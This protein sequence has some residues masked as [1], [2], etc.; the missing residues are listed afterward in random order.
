VKTS[1]VSLRARR[2][3]LGAA[4]IFCVLFLGSCRAIL[5]TDDYE[6]SIDVFCGM[7][8]RCF[9]EDA[10]TCRTTVF[11]ELTDAFPETRKLWLTTFSD[12]ACF[13]RCVSTRRCMNTPPVCSFDVCEKREDCCFFVQGQK[14]CNLGTN[15]CCIRKGSRC[16]TDEDCCPGAGLCTTD[17]LPG[18]QPVCGG[19]ACGIPG[20]PCSIGAQCCTEV[21]R[22][23]VCAEDICSPD[24]L[25]CGSDD[26]CCEHFCNE[27]TG[28]CGKEVCGVETEDCGDGIPCCGEL[29]CYNGKCTSPG[30]QPDGIE[31]SQHD[32]CCGKRCDADLTACRACTDAGASCGVNGECCSG[33]CKDGFCAD[34]L[35]E[36]EKCVLGGATDCCLGSC[37][38]VDPSAAKVDMRCAPICGPLTCGHDECVAG[39]PLKADCS[40]CTQAVCAVDSYCCC[41]EWDSF[42]VSEALA[43]CPNP[44]G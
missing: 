35:P 24:G 20:T 43:I 40:P 13:D 2:R 44:C 10:E 12:D 29:F 11:H 9:G 26:D 30:C 31:C 17:G 19:V 21:C 16:R 41:K 27:A 37:Q 18:S 14:D 34:C 33:F 42:C 36:G 22:D 3:L 8:A 7:L 5:G 39:P 25:E 6:N 32:Q 38:D 15:K 4:A 1:R 23:N 28:L